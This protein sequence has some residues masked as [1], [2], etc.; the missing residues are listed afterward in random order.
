VISTVAVVLDEFADAL[1]ELSWQI[2]VFQR[3]PILNCI[4]SSFNDDAGRDG[5]T[6]IWGADVPSGGVTRAV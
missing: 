4:S 1:F 5:L 2:V 6:T 3:D